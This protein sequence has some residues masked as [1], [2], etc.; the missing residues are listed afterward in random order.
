[1]HPACIQVTC[2]SCF[3][4][5]DYN[6]NKIDN[7]WRHNPMWIELIDGNAE[8]K[9]AHD[10]GRFEDWLI[11]KGYMARRITTGQISAQ[12]AIQA[13]LPSIRYVLMHW[14]HAIAPCSAPRNPYSAHGDPSRVPGTMHLQLGT[15]AAPM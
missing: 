5:Y 13:A 2:T 10:S 11:A 7:G 8:A 9:A 15:L 1:M 12:E 4:T 6:T 14:D 3:T